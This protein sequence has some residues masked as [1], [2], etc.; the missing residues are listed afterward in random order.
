[1][2]IQSIKNSFVQIDT[3]CDKIPVLSSVTNLLEIFA[4]SVLFCYSK[5]KGING[6]ELKERHFTHLNDKSLK[7]N[8]ILLVPLINI[9]AAC[10]FQ[11]PTKEQILKDLYLFSKANN[12]LRNDKDFVLQAVKQR[13]VALSFASEDLKNDRDVVLEAVKQNGVALRFASE[14]LKNDREVVL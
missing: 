13:G 4:K 2:N 12:R 6:K 9:A 3:F 14:D 5:I 11:G 8:L 1:M 10:M 7:E